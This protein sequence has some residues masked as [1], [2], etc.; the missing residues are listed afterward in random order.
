[1]ITN[2]H[3]KLKKISLDLHIILN[4]NNDIISGTIPAKSGTH[5]FY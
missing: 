2:N 1:M 5:W 3:G 4:S